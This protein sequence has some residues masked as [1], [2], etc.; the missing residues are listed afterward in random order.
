MGVAGDG[1]TAQGDGL[2]VIVRARVIVDAHGAAPVVNLAVIDAHDVGVIDVAVVLRLEQFGGAEVLVVAVPR[3][4]LLHH[5]FLARLVVLHKFFLGQVAVLVVFHALDFE[6]LN[7]GLVDDD[8]A[9]V[10]LPRRAGEV[11]LVFVCTGADLQVRAAREGIVG[12]VGDLRGFQGLPVV[13]AL[14]GILHH[15]QFLEVGTAL[16]G[17]LVDE[18]VEGEQR[19]VVV[20]VG[21]LEVERR[22]LRAVAEGMGRDEAQVGMVAQVAHQVVMYLHAVA[23]VFV[24]VVARDGRDERLLIFAV[25]DDHAGIVVVVAERIAL[26]RHVLVADVVVIVLAR[27][28]AV[29]DAPEGALGDG[30]RDGVG[31]VA[32][33]HGFVHILQLVNAVARP[34]VADEGAA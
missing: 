16:E 5:G 24:L 29:G 26:G 19:V 18:E 27:Q 15:L 14:R 30:R 1:L 32:Q 31:V 21:V 3:D 6:V 17:A 7:G 11:V 10:L 12:H 2:V 25:I 34:R 9:A 33:L 13:G 23:V 20:G 8:A 22:Q 28:V 4:D